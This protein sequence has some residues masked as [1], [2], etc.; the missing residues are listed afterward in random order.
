MNCLGGLPHGEYLAR[1]QSLRGLLAARDIGAILLLGRRNWFG[2]HSIRYLVG[3]QAHDDLAILL[4]LKDGGVRL[5][6]E[7]DETPEPLLPADIVSVHATHDLVATVLDAI[8]RT[9]AHAIGVAGAECMGFSAVDL[10]PG[11]LLRGL[12]AQSPSL[13]LVDLGD[14]LLRMRMVRSPTE[15]AHLRESA[16][17]AERGAEAFFATVG[18]G[19]S[20]RDVW[21]E[22]W[23]AMQ[24][25]GAEDV[26]IS[27]CRGPGSFWPHPPSDAKFEAGDIVSI[28][29]SPRYNGYFS[30]SNRMCFLGESNREWSDLEFLA[31]ESLRVAVG[32]IRPGVKASDVVGQVSAF[33]AK[34]PLATMDVGGVHRVGHGCGLAIDEGPFLTSASGTILQ[35]D[36]TLAVHPIIYLPYRHSLLMLGD[37]VRVTE[38]GAEVVTRAQ[39]SIPVI[40]ART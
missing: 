1:L 24:V 13:E 18:I 4:I 32:A 25:A 34:S 17:I 40:G 11:R 6:V 27:M 15:L 35:P 16:L 14:D 36:M 22:V 2:D 5:Y 33:V 31:M 20:E 23:H 8:G 3:Y 37:Y 19:V 26:H 21:S 28:E 12:R 10:L 9:D 7:S 29:I 30:Q 39:E 38:D